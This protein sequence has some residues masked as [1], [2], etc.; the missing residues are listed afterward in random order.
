MNAKT[1]KR[2][3]ALGDGLYL[4]NR[5]GSYLWR[6]RVNRRPVSKRLRHPSGAVATIDNMTKTEARR[7]AKDIAADAANG[8]GRH[9]GV[10]SRNAGAG[11]VTVEK[12]WS[13]YWKREASKLG[14]S[15]QKHTHWTTIIQPEWGDRELSSIT[16]W[17]CSKLVDKRLNEALDAGQAGTAANNLQKTLKRF[18]A[19]CAD[20]G[21]GATGLDVSPMGGL[22]KKAVDVK[23]TKRPS[24]ALAEAELRWLFR[25][26][27][28]YVATVGH[29]ETPEN[30]RRIVE[31][32][33]SLL[34]SLCRREDVFA[35]RWGWLR[36]D[37]LLIPRTK[38]G[39][40]LLVP[41]TPAMRT[42]IGKRP[43]DADDD[44]LIWSF[45]VSHI[46]HGIESIRE[47]MTGIARADG[48]KGDFSTGKFDGDHNPHYWTLH[49]FRDTGKTWMGRQMREDDMP[50]YPREVTEA[51][52][53]HREGG[54]GAIYNADIESPYWALAQRKRAGEAWNSFL[55]RVKME[56]LALL[57]AA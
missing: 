3:T 21:Y 49:D 34:R 28:S 33:E 31:A 32:H 53:N 23:K 18:F 24:R 48:F 40:P 27:E 2:E 6:G 36:D 55:D 19:W 20:E 46:A 42:L 13:D 22:K 14:S 54:I 7:T 50:L 30:K 45:S 26:F 35:A 56:A 1:A 29:K 41:L 39:H 12:A 38:M 47:H 8:T 52:L 10:T 44:S 37:G 25:A 5:S 16:K 57:L 43:A 17:D 4:D 9:F 11:G 15:G 51:M